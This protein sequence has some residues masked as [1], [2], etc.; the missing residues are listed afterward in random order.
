MSAQKALSMSYSFESPHPSLSHPACFMRL[1]SQ[2]IL[3]LLQTV[4]RLKN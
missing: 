1:L 4:D 2:V 3:I